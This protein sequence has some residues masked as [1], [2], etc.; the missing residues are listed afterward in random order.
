MLLSKY[1]K[2]L[3]FFE[4]QCSTAWLAKVDAERGNVYNSSL[5]WRR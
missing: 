4:T 2:W 3:R 5:L 1:I